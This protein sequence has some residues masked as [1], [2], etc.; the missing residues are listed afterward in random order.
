MPYKPPAEFNFTEPNSRPSWKER[1]HH[2]R[3]ATEL[4]KKDGVIQV[5][6]LLYSM[7][8]EA[9]RVFAPFRFDRNDDKNDFDK[10]VKIFDDH[11]IP[12]RNVIHERAT[13]HR[14]D[15]KPG[16]TVEQYIRCLYEL[17]EHADFSEKEETSRD[18]IVLGLLDKEL[19]EKLQ[20]QEGL[21]L[22]QATVMARQHERVKQ[23]LAMQRSGACASISSVDRHKNKSSSSKLK[24]EKRESS[25]TCGRCGLTYDKGKCPAKE[26]TCHKC[27]KSSHFAK[28]CRSKPAGKMI[29]RVE[30]KE[31]KAEEESKQTFFIGS[32]ASAGDPWRVKLSVEGT[33]IDFKI[34]T[35]ADV[36]V[37]GRST[38]QSLGQPELS[39]CGGV[40]LHSPGGVM[41]TLGKFQA[42]VDERL[43]IQIFVTDNNVDSLLSRNTASALSLVKRVDSTTFSTVNCK[44]VKIK[45]CE[46]AKPCS[47]S[48]ARR[49]PIPLEENVN[50]EPQR[51]KD[52]GII[53]EITEPTEWVAGMVPVVKPNGNIRICVDLKNSIKLS[54]ENVTSFPP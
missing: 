26:E 50:N 3:I 14:R 49:V 32:V 33:V 5:S 43:L 2:F 10:V 9:D 20:L 45:L 47:I 21:T 31:P 51:M 42:V 18:R 19:S 36:N 37:I 29:N 8:A 22:R 16:E 24:G 15:Q 39:E 41:K 13:F 35:G 23:E 7:G 46:G 53:E 1:F 4:N 17:A 11:F 6:S 48:T 12:K 34:D 25:S 54:K 28:V 52:E 40:T 30:A 44:P 27:G 38:W